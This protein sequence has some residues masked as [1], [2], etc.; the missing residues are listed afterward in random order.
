MTLLRISKLLDPDPRPQCG[1]GK[2]EIE[3][4]MDPL[5]QIRNTGATKIR[6]FS[7]AASLNYIL[8]IIK[9][10]IRPPWRYNVLCMVPERAFMFVTDSC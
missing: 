10:T 2:K 5:I 8:F 3:I 1:S 4:V 9:Q 6:P 7:V